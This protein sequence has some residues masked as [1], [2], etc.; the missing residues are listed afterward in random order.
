MKSKIQ[1]KIDKFLQDNQD[2]KNAQ[3]SRKLIASRFSILGIQ[4]KKLES[5]AKE[6]LKRG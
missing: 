3:F 4:T 6:L 1:E 5:F 2:E